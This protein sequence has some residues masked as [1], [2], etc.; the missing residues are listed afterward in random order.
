MSAHRKTRIEMPVPNGNVASASSSSKLAQQPQQRPRRSSTL[1]SPPAYNRPYLPTLLETLGLA[2]YPATLLMGS[3]F[4]LLHPSTRASPYL[5]HTQAYDPNHAPSYFAQKKNVFNLYF[6]KIGWFW[7]SLAFLL[8]LFTSKSLGPPGKPVITRKRAQAFLRYV[9]ITLVWVAV[10]QWFFGPP[11]VDRGFRWTGGK[12][13]AVL[14]GW[15]EGDVQQRFGMAATHAACKALGGQWKGGH[16]ISGHVFLLILS[17]GMLWLEIL[18]AILSVKGLRE[19]RRVKMADGLVRSAVV[20]AMEEDVQPIKKDDV[21]AEDQKPSIGIQAALL[22]A[23]LSWW[24]LL[25]TAA[26]FHTWFE[27]FTGLLVAFGAL[28]VVYFLPRGVPAWR[29]VVGMPGV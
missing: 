18:P 2:L 6:V 1:D 9:C 15:E 25:M 10:T 20:E 7:T 29:S 12:C 21:K 17:S 23:G 4:S 24:M 26:Y 13:E 28:Y 14:Q 5:P 27:K 8:L 19:A 22:V 11:I 3:L 16:D